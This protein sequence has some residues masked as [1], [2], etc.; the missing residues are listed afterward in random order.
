M[1]FLF[2]TA[3]EQGLLGSAYYSEFPVYPLAKTVAVI[4]VDTINAWGRTKDLTVIGLGASQLDDYLRAAATEQGRTLRPDPESEKGFYYRSDHFNFA[5]KGVPALYTDA[6]VEYEGKDA[7]YG[8]Q[9]RDEYTNRDY[10]RPSDEVKDDWDLTGAVDDARLLMAVGYRVANAA[11]WPEWA[12]DNEFRAARETDAR[13]G[14]ETVVATFASGFVAQSVVRS[15]ASCACGGP[16]HRHVELD[17][18]TTLGVRGGCG[19][20]SAIDEERERDTRR[21]VADREL[22]FLFCRRVPGELD[23][24]F[25]GRVGIDAGRYQDG[26]ALDVVVILG[27]DLEGA[28]E[29]DLSLRVAHFRDRSVREIAGGRPRLCIELHHHVDRGD[30]RGKK[31]GKRNELTLVFHET[32]LRK[33]DWEQGSDRG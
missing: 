11:Q 1:L 15:V 14:G 19:D 22:H 30:H 20:D 3:E 26:L 18:R 25:T 31:A 8:T 12:S 33:H 13:H 6:G 10:H 29:H 17:L 7:N 5:K 2:V 9:K 28:A 21:Q 32:P 24:G 16:G 23:L 27:S 4:N